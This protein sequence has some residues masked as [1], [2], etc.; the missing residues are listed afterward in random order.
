MTMPQIRGMYDGDRAR[1]QTL[2]DYGFRLPSRPG[3]PPAELRGVRASGSTRW[4]SCRATPGAVS[5]CSNSVSSRASRS[6]GRPACSTPRSRCGRPTGRSTTSSSEIRDRVRAQE[7]VL[8]TT[9]TKRMAEDLTRVPA[10]DRHQG[11]L[12]ALR[13]RDAGT[14]RDPA[15]PAPRRVRRA[16]RH[17]PAA[18]GPG[19]AGGLAG[20]H[21]RRRQGGLPARRDEPHPDHRPRRPQRERQGHHVRRHA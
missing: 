16:G 21:P 4:S 20:R 5:S 19:P 9:L 8:V 13:D 14:H 12:P 1:K 3:Q 18:R 15:R 2:V 11:A 10:R 6:S 7:R 17:Q